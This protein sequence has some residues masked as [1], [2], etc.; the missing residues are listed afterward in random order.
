MSTSNKRTV[1]GNFIHSVWTSLNLRC[2]N[3]KYRQLTKKNTSYEKV[4]IE[5]SRIEFKQWC[6][7]REV[8]IQALVRPSIDRK[9]KELGYTLENIQ[10]ME[11]AENIR[12]DKTVFYENS[13]R[14][15]CCKEVKQLEDFARSN[16]TQNGREAT[17]KRCDSLRKRVPEQL[18][19]RSLKSN[20][21]YV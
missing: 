2:A 18:R 3:G 5:F 7:E 4:N 1:V 12:K 13:G 11:L 17:C 15:R 9:N 20:V 21:I 6:L 10:V 16:R 14:C 19:Q 8:E